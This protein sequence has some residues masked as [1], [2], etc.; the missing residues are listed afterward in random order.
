MKVRIY[1]D[2]YNDVL[3]II[4]QNF[5]TK[6]YGNKLTEAE[7]AEKIF[8][9]I[10]GIATNKSLNDGY[11]SAEINFKTFY[12]ITKSFKV[13]KSIISKLVKLDLIKIQVNNGDYKGKV[14]SSKYRLSNS[15]FIDFSSLNQGLNPKLELTIDEVIIDDSLNDSLIPFSSS[16]NNVDHINQIILSHFETNVD[17]QQL[18]NE[19]TQKCDN[20]NL[21]SIKNDISQETKSMEQDLEIYKYFEL[22]H[23]MLWN[24]DLTFDEKIKL[25]KQI[26]KHEPAKHVDSNKSYRLTHW[27]HNLKSD[28]RKFIT[29][30]DSHIEEIWDK[31]CCYPSMIAVLCKDKISNN[32]LNRYVNLVQTGDIYIEALKHSGL[33]LELRD[34]IKSYFQ[35]F[36]QGKREYSLKVYNMKADFWNIKTKKWT[37]PILMRAV[38]DFYKDKFPQIYNCILNW[39]IRDTDGKK[40]ISTECSKLEKELIQE[41]ICKNLTCAW[42]TIHDAIFIRTEDKNKINVNFDLEFWKLAGFDIINLI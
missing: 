37:K 16:I 14:H 40:T 30:F 19:K 42:F 22:D 6:V 17:N 39:T 12:S 4:N 25:E 1:K 26:L 2:L 3:N 7:K 18:I 20:Y 13:T 36:I 8:L 24:S 29:L 23:N 38:M 11:Y 34:E 9:L 27:I 28:Y 32:E 10:Y 41:G 33:D 35:I 15:L 21:E 5:S 31:R